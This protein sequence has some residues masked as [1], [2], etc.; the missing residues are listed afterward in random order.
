MRNCPI[1]ERRGGKL[2][3]E[4]ER[5]E[6]PLP[7]KRWDYRGSDRLWWEAAFIQVGT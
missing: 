6:V 2:K 4:E 7:P 3:R 1:R 5:E